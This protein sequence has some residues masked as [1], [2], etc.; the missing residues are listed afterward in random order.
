MSEN[1]KNQIKITHIINTGDGLISLTLEK[2]SEG[3]WVV[4]E[5]DSKGSK[6]GIV[7]KVDIFRWRVEGFMEEI[8]KKY[9]E[10][11]KTQEDL[12]EKIYDLKG[13]K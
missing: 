1:L 8:I 7:L 10:F 6:E 4:K 11:D 2:T 9:Q 5:Y 3:F 13:L 12:K